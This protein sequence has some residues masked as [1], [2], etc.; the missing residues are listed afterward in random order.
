M[1]ERNSDVMCLVFICVY[2]IIYRDRL[3]YTPSTHSHRDTCAQCI[4]LFF[5]LSSWNLHCD[6][7]FGNSE[8]LQRVEIILNIVKKLVI[9]LPSIN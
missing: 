7:S 5:L 6:N 3:V 2:I 1:Y 4:F 8:V 9:V